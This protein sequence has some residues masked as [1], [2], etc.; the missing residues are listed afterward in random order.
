VF[1]RKASLAGVGRPRVVVCSVTGIQHDLERCRVCAD[2]VAN[3]AKKLLHG[4]S[5]GIV[6]LDATSIV[7]DFAFLFRTAY[8]DAISNTT[9]ICR[10]RST[11]VFC[12]CERNEHIVW[13]LCYS[14][15]PSTIVDDVDDYLMPEQP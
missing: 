4:T 11:I 5:P 14:A 10:I 8:F 12:R 2:A 13:M 3:G 7:L 9:H 1:T 6:A 15:M